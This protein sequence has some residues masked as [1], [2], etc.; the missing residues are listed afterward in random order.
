MESHDG[1]WVGVA[2]AAFARLEGFY[3]GISQRP[4]GISNAVIQAQIFDDCVH[5]LSLVFRIDKPIHCRY[6]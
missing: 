4:H 6:A 3:I 1:F 5:C 2:F